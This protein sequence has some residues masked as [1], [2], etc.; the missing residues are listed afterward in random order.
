MKINNHQYVINSQGVLSQV[1]PDL[2]QTVYD[3]KYV[4]DRYAGIPEKRIAMSHLRYGFMLGAIGK[5]DSILEIGYG[6]GDFIGLCASNSIQCYGNDITKLPPPSNVNQ[7]NDIYK[8]VD[9]VAMFDVLEHF[10]DIDFVK[11]LN[12]NYVYLSVPNCHYPQDETYLEIVYPHLR[13]NEHLHHFNLNSLEQHMFKNGY[14]LVKW[15][16]PED[17]IR[18][19]PNY[20][21]NIL[22]AIFERRPTNGKE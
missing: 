1:N 13:P 4:L 12:C 21:N 14:Q 15:G 2:T 10:E 6:A 18:Q 20:Y 8:S 5:P 9:V 17:A 11:D 16:H 3:A 7:T 19:R 22:T